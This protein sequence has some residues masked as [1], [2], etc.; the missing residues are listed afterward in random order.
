MSLRKD[1]VRVLAFIKKVDSVSKEEFSRYWA[2][3][4][5]KIFMA[6]PIAKTN[7]LKYEQVGSRVDL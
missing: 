4:H 7:L 1:R 3:E 6:M 5:S 2:E